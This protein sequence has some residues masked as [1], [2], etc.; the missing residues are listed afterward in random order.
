M[1]TQ[2][3]F[4]AYEQH[5]RQSIWLMWSIFSQKHFTWK[6]SFRTLSLDSTWLCR[7]SRTPRSG[8]SAALSTK[9][10]W[11]RWRLR[12]DCTSISIVHGQSRL[13]WPLSWKPP[14]KVSISGFPVFLVQCMQCIVENNRALHELALSCISN[15]KL[16]LE[17]FERSISYIVSTGFTTRNQTPGNYP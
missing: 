14:S 4:A 15:C 9:L 10:A 1:D 2:P 17:R 11:A 6:G 8:S 7:P 16:T 5:P 13:Q 3:P 12:Q